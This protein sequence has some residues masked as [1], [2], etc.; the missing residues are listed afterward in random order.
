[1]NETFTKLEAKLDKVERD[2]CSVRD[3]IINKAKYDNMRGRSIISLGQKYQRL[4]VK[5]CQIENEIKDYGPEEV[6]K[7]GDKMSAICH[8]VKGAKPC[9]ECRLLEYVNKID[10]WQN[11]GKIEPCDITTE[12]N[13]N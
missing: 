8:C 6:T 5:R 7:K 9:A 10:G 4:E 12:G 13:K 11:Y 2:M 3:D 1:M